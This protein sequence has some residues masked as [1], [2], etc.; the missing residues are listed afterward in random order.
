AVIVALWTAAHRG[1]APWL[2]AVLAAV[3]LVPNLTRN[4]FRVHP[5]RWAFFTQGW[6]RMCFPQ[7]EN[8]AIFPFGFWG[9]S[10]LW[11]AESGFSF[12][13][14]EGSLGPEPPPKNLASDPTI[15][16]LT[17]TTQ[18]PT[19]AQIVAFAKNKQVDRILSVAIYV[20]PN[21]TQM[22]RFGE[23]QLVQGV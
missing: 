17:Y 1:I 22:R 16:M 9:S 19:P 14:P 12:R 23:V 18:F 11:Q 21:G 5:E 4:E 2:L 7:N 6:Y 3:S 15:Q 13:M 10:M 20:H 8:V